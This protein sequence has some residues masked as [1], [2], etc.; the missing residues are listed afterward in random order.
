KGLL[1][2][3]ALGGLMAWAG[4]K[5]AH[6]QAAE[7]GAAG[8]TTG[9]TIEPAATAPGTPAPR[10]IGFGADPAPAVA[11]APGTPA[12]R[13]IGFGA[14]PAPAAPAGPALAGPPVPEQGGPAP[15]R[16]APTARPAL[17]VPG[18]ITRPGGV[19]P[20]GPRASAPEGPGRPTRPGGPE[21]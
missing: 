15:A 14:D 1:F 19:A 9:T 5:V 8:G 21:G 3:L 10:P 7:P 13:P 20:E 11:P 4:G 18:E 17:E 2:N 6:G 12:P 16:Q